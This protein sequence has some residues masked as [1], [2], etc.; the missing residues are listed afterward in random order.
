MT[1]SS[2]LFILIRYSLNRLKFS[3]FSRSGVQLFTLKRNIAFPLGWILFCIFLEYIHR[4]C[5][6]IQPWINLGQKAN[7]FLLLEPPS[8]LIISLDLKLICILP[9]WDY[10]KVYFD[11]PL[12]NI[13]GQFLKQFP[14]PFILNSWIIQ[15]KIL[16]IFQVKRCGPTF[17]FMHSSWFRSLHL[18]NFLSTK[19]LLTI[20]S[21]IQRTLEWG[22]DLYIFTFWWNIGEVLLSSFWFI[23]NIII[24]NL[25]DEHHQCNALSTETMMIHQS[26]D[27]SSMN[28]SKKYS[29]NNQNKIVSLKM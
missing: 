7:Q 4:G 25:F 8:R 5:T 16:N 23:H 3:H 29:M 6:R 28:I 18:L 24:F 15:I 9:K 21:D 14:S 22:L 20:S 1:P 13:F 12:Y 10:F 26:S 27:N 19:S 2:W 11:P 17:C